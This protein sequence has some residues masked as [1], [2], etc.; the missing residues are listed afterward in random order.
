MALK[1]KRYVLIAMA[2][3]A[4]AFS[5][6]GFW[7]EPYALEI[8]HHL[9]RAPIATKLRIAH[10]TDLHSRGLGRLERKLLAALET[11]K[12]DLIVI[13]GDSISSG[14]MNYARSAEVLSRLHAPLGVWMVK[15]NWEVWNPIRD[16]RRYYDAAGVKLLVNETAIIRDGVWLVGLNDWAAGV[17]NPEETFDKVPP[18]A[19]TIALFHSPI[20]FDSVS[21]RCDLAFAGHTHGGQVRLPPIGA[22][23]TPRGCGSY[24]AGWYERGRSRMYVS[25]GIGTSIL[26]VRLFC[27][28]E[29]AII[30]VGPNRDGLN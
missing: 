25:R 3:L 24:L 8:T 21:G 19:F 9:I 11:E 22:L 20:V 7:I 23:W 17:R 29:L 10:L 14:A 28:P 12:P 27:P 15:G 18:G 5:I 16:E 26:G 4:L 30:D 1:W 13:T 2:S 6:Y